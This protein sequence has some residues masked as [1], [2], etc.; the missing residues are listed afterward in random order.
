MIATAWTLWGDQFHD[1]GGW[2]PILAVATVAVVCTL[3]TVWVLVRLRR[4]ESKGAFDPQRR[5]LVL[6]AGLGLGAL[7]LPALSLTIGS[8]LA[9]PAFL[10]GGAA[11]RPGASRRRGL[12]L[13]GLVYLFTGFVSVTVVDA[14]IGRSLSAN[15]SE[16]LPFLLEIALWP[17]VIA[18]YKDGSYGR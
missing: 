8:L 13:G 17:L 11:L 18:T 3:V 10:V 2:P 4:P 14:L 12:V 5:P 16:P 6:A 7:L 9:I 1:S 15:L